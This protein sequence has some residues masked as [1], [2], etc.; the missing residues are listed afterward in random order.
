[1]P[2]LIS[3][4]DVKIEDFPTEGKNF[5]Y[6]MYLLVTSY[7]LNPKQLKYGLLYGTDFTKA[8]AFNNP[9]VY[10][11]HCKLRD[12]MNLEKRIVTIDCARN[13]LEYFTKNNH[14]PPPTL[15]PDEY[16]YNR[17]LIIQVTGMMKR[18]R[19]IIDFQKCEIKT[20]NKTDIITRVRLQ[21]D[22]HLINFL[23]RLLD[24]CPIEWKYD[25]NYTYG[26]NELV[27]D[28][29][30]VTSQFDDDDIY[31]TQVGYQTRTKFRLLNEMP[32]RNNNQ[33]DNI[34]RYPEAIQRL[35]RNIIKNEDSTL[36]SMHTNDTRDILNP[37]ENR[38]LSAD[39][40]NGINVSEEIT[41]TNNETQSLIETQPLTQTPYVNRLEPSS[42]IISNNSNISNDD[43]PYKEVFVCGYS[44]NGT[45]PLLLKST[46]TGKY[47]INDSFELYIK[48]SFESNKYYTLCFPTSDDIFKLITK[49][50]ELEIPDFSSK[51]E[52]FIRN[53]ISD[54]FTDF[55]LKLPIQIYEKFHKGEKYAFAP[56]YE[57]TAPEHFLYE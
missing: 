37:N 54:K 24:E 10:F 13:E 23:K 34:A 42:P 20:L 8:D 17:K 21:N 7:R 46:T 39:E 11:N 45:E 49:G 50:K 35:S 19:R 5:P 57:S 47:I 56:S 32:V 27:D 2:T 51:D 6:R 22:Q 26:L 44:P 36:L 40:I 3:A 16:A 33:I 30:T 55:V 12:N 38:E 31:D 9:M 4:E 52:E 1:M 53:L 29:G 25:L 15:N 14:L 28:I 43:R 41:T 48:L 18:Y